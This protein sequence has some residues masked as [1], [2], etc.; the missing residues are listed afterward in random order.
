MSEDATLCYNVKCTDSQIYAYSSG[1]DVSIDN[2][3]DI[4]QF[5]KAVHPNNN[6]IGQRGY[7]YNINTTYNYE[8]SNFTIH[9]LKLRYENPYYALYFDYTV[10]NNTN[11]PLIWSINEHDNVYGDVTTD[12][13]TNEWLGGN[14]NLSDGDFDHNCRKDRGEIEPN[15]EM[16]GTMLLLFNNWDEHYN[17]IKLRENEHMIFNLYY[18]ENGVK[19]AY[20]VELN[21]SE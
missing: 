8:Q 18:T 11:Q 7:T 4:I 6:E 14:T 13:M 12:T 1:E 17:T 3:A 2:A 19:S 5:E 21:E 9:R 10:K 20:T 16:Y 15:G